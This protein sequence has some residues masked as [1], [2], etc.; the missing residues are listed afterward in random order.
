MYRGST[1]SKAYNKPMVDNS[2]R[3]SL[4]LLLAVNP[5]IVASLPSTPPK[6]T[7]PRALNIG[8]LIPQAANMGARITFALLPVVPT[9]VGGRMGA[10]RVGICGL[11]IM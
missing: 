5:G 3:I 11:G 1:H 4:K 8:H 9:V 10:R 6:L 2:K 7:T